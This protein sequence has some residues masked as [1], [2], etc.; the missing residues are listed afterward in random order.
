MSRVDVINHLTLDGVMQAPGR[1][2]E[3]NARRVCARRLVSAERGRS[4]AG[5]D[6]RSR[7]GEW[8]AASAARPSELR[9]HARLLEHAG[10][11]VQR[12][13][14][15]R[16][17]IRRI[18]NAARA[19]PLAQLDAPPRRCRRR[20]H[21]AQARAERRSNRDGKRRTHPNTHASGLNRRVPA[22][23]PPTRPRHRPTIP[24]PAPDGRSR[25][26]ASST[27]D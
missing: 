27:S 22:V 10:Q 25:H 4:A 26:S 16:T 2:D 8:W 23:H 20:R 9:G 5:G 19:A 13:A 11:P 24:S 12:R 6:I 1:P 15:Q 3:D 14:Q 7:C 21:R 18:Q 17:Q